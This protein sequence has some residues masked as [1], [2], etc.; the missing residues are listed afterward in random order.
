MQLDKNFVR[1]L[2]PSIADRLRHGDL[3]KIAQSTGYT[4]LTIRNAVN[5]ASTNEAAVR[6]AIRTIL[7][8]AKRTGDFL[9][10]IPPEVIESILRT[11]I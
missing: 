8:D 11:T 4:P 2:N 3:L 10:Q 7:E 1:N 9:E 6:E 5:G